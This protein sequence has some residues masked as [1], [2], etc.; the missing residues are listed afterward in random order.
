MVSIRV[1]RHNQ[2]CATKYVGAHRRG[3]HAP[4]DEPLSPSS[5]YCS[6]QVVPTRETDNCLEFT[7]LMHTTT[8][9]QEHLGPPWPLVVA[10][11]ALARRRVLKRAGH[12]AATRV[13]LH[14]LLYSHR[15]CWPRHA[16]KQC[17]CSRRL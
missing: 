5:P 17:R 10:L 15:G 9:V 12:R 6:H 8:G 14:W 11:S 7:S 13:C 4:L 3:L 2:C 1:S 16:A